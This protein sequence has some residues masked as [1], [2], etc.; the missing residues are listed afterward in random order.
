MNEQKNS[1]TNVVHA[2]NADLIY[3][4]GSPLSSIP[5]NQT[6]AG[7]AHGST[8]S[9]YSDDPSDCEPDYRILTANLIADEPEFEDDIRPIVPPLVR[10]DGKRT[11][12]RH[13]IKTLDRA[14]AR[15]PYEDQSQR[16][17]ALKYFRGRFSTSD[18]MQEQEGWMENISLL[19]SISPF[20]L[21][22][23]RILFCSACGKLCFQPNWCRR[24]NLDQ[25][26]EPL[27][28]MFKNAYA[29]RPFWTSLV[30]N[31]EMDSNKAGIWTGPAENRQALYLPHKGKPN[32]QFL[33]FS[34]HQI[35]FAEHFYDFLF[36][37]IR[38]LKKIG[39]IDGWIAVA[40]PSLSFWP[41]PKSK[42]YLWNDIAHAFL[43]HVHVLVCGHHPFDD[44]IIRSI[45]GVMQ[46]F[47]SGWSHANFWFNQVTSQT[48]I[49]K[50]INYCVKPFPLAKWY[51]DALEAGC[52]EA[53]LNLV[54]DDIAL[55][56]CP[57]LMSRIHSPRRGG[58]LAT[59]SREACI[60][61]CL[62]PLLTR[63]QIAEC[64]NGSFYSEHE[65]AFW[66]TME[67]RDLRRGRDFLCKSKS[68]E[69]AVGCISAWEQ[70]RDNS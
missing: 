2:S 51:S 10:F 58:V 6:I 57:E 60:L 43:P 61:D 3:T 24:C 49:R 14:Y 22:P 18:W 20:S 23:N 70:E 4:H 42:F 63:K 36:W 21:N 40:E 66:R 12:Y 38:W 37:V 17:E 9:L 13:V 7:E 19:A 55:E 68:H 59:N 34:A 41:N 67:K 27:Q 28:A 47:I 16:S 35:D 53:T 52:D 50:W 33:R 11:N 32:G 15:R 56:S 69:E 8:N 45:Y 29:K 64:K 44:K 46:D 30:L 65:D 39:I 54:F 26:V 25:R 1:R 31:Y 5:H 48:G 62:P